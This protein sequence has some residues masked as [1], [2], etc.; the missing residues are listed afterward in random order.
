MR[1]LLSF[2]VAIVAEKLVAPQGSKEGIMQVLTAMV[3]LADV[4]F[5]VGATLLT[6]CWEH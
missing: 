6:E 2:A 3:L 1:L 4:L 5:K